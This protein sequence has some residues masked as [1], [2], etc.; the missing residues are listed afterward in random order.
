MRPECLP[1]P[2]P[3]PNAN[4][5]LAALLAPLS[6]S[7]GQAGRLR[8]AKVSSR[9]APVNAN[10]SSCKVPKSLMQIATKSRSWPTMDS[11]FPRRG[12]RSKNWGDQVCSK[13][14]PRDPKSKRK[15]N[16]KSKSHTREK[17]QD[18]RRIAMSWGAEGGGKLREQREAFGKGSTPPRHHSLRRASSSKL[19]GKDFQN[20]SSPFALE[21]PSTSCHACLQGRGTV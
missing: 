19:S 15:S 6:S 7:D 12:G 9:T 3:T 18:R 4:S 2:Q 11:S 8:I 5:L 13:E 14:G 10:R 17:R 20:C 16:G 1:R 21:Q